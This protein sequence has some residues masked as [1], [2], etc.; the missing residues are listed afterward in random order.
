M[1][2]NFYILK[3]GKVRISKKTIIK[4]KNEKIFNIFEYYSYVKHKN[5]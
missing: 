5:Q 3:T 1:P 2:I 4:Q